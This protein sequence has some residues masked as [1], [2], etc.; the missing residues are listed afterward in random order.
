MN[1][2]LTESSGEMGNERNYT[3]FQYD[4]NAQNHD[5][6]IGPEPKRVLDED[7]PYQ[8]PV[9]LYI[10]EEIILVEKVFKNCLINYQANLYKLVLKNYYSSHQQ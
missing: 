9:G 4:Y 1:G 10:P 3:A 7:A 5:I 8:K 6:C 2:M